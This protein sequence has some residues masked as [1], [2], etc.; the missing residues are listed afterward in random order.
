M[1]RA[2]SELDGLARVGKSCRIRDTW[3]TFPTDE[4]GAQRLGAV[5]AGW[6]NANYYNNIII[7]IQSKWREIWV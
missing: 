7:Y 3:A 6:L 1:E 2:S 4:E 5:E